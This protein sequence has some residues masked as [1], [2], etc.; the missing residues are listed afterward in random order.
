MLG[1]SESFRMGEETFRDS[2][3]LMVEQSLSQYVVPVL[4]TVPV[5]LVGNDTAETMLAFN[6][7]IADVGRAYGVPVVNLWLATQPLPSNG[8]EADRIH[9]TNNVAL[10]GNF[11]GAQDQYAA[12]MWNLLSL[13]ILEKFRLLGAG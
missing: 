6:M 4:F 7:I 1:M 11:T 13:Q 5:S 9:P 10:A 2:I 12:T 3:E 8:L